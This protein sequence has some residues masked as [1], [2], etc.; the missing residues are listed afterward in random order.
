MPLHFSCL[1]VAKNRGSQRY[2]MMS[3][4]QLVN[5][6]MKSALIGS[7]DIKSVLST[8]VRTWLICFPRLEF[9]WFGFLVIEVLQTES[10]RGSG[11]WMNHREEIQQIQLLRSTLCLERKVAKL[12]NEPLQIM[13]LVQPTMPAREPLR[14]K[15]KGNQIFKILRTLYRRDSG[16]EQCLTLGRTH[17]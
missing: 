14:R 9:C 8:S 16:E 4:S 5:R 6:H 3:P 13:R 2:L 10:P 15:I 17:W 7:Q 1:N 12:R 11:R